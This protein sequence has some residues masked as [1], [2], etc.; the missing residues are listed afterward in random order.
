MTGTRTYRMGA[1]ATSVEAT[2]RRIVQATVAL[3]EEEFSDLI[4][5]EDIAAAAGVTVPTVLR[6]FGS[7]DQ[8]LWAAVDLTESEVR[9]QR[10]QAPVGDIAG[11]VDNL[12]D[13]YEERGTTVLRLLAQEERV[14]QLRS[15]LDRGRAA[16]REW[17]ER[18]FAPLLPR[19]DRDL[20][21]TKLVVICDVYVWKLLVVDAQHDRTATHQLLVEMIEDVLRRGTT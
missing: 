12:L 3:H 2:R 16:H 18:T 21:V 17:V 11:A 7:K 8:L 15:M 1:R 6:H 19:T 5:L 10:W 9:E 13:H 4:T 14:P 20:A